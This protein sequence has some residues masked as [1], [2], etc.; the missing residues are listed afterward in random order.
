ML[1]LRDIHRNLYDAIGFN[2]HPP[3]GVNATIV[4][5]PADAEKFVEF[6]WAPTLGGE[7]YSGV[8]PVSGLAARVFQWAPTLGG[9][10]YTSGAHPSSQKKRCFNGHPP[11]GVNATV[12]PYAALVRG[13]IKF[14]W[15]PTLGGECYFFAG[16]AWKL[17]YACCFNG[18]PP[19]GVNATVSN[20]SRSRW[21]TPCFNGHPPLGVNA[22][23][24]CGFVTGRL[25]VS[26]GTHPWG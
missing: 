26:M 23:G 13:E 12:D 6:Q 7:C 2:G 24:V 3:L 16:A 5:Y 21:F 1:P 8:R 11:L 22:T 4:E 9:E 20:M 17:Q 15:A 18:H 19:L 14:Q 10:C 25:Y